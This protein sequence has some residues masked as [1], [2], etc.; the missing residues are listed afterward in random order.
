MP[1]ETPALFIKVF[2]VMNIVIDKKWSFHQLC[3][4][5]RKRLLFVKGMHMIWNFEFFYVLSIGVD[6][7]EMRT[8]Y[9]HSSSV[10]TLNRI[11]RWVL[12]LKHKITNVKSERINGLFVLNFPMKSAQIC[13]LFLP[14]TANFHEWV[15]RL[16]CYVNAELL[17][18][19][20]KDAI[21]EFSPN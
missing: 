8:W 10:F 17:S 11:K 1:R 19:F 13:Y 21:L 9:K 3:S 5:R 7:I 20:R 16:K 14:I 4:V 6:V 15:L 12:H 2:I 18:D